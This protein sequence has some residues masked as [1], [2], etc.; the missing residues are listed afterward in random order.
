[1][2]SIIESVIYST[3]NSKVKETERQYNQGLYYCTDDSI[4]STLKRITDIKFIQYSFLK[5]RK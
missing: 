1:M 4:Y 2:A 5:E 3:Q